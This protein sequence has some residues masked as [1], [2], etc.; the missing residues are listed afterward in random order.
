[1]S[2]HSQPTTLQEW[3]DETDDPTPPT[4]DPE[5]AWTPTAAADGDD[6]N[7]CRG[8][9]EHVSSDFVRVYSA[10][11][12]GLVHACPACCVHAE[13]PAR[14]AG[15]QPRGPKGPTNVEDL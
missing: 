12:E 2:S 4:T 15:K 11:G 6:A 3:T 1:M 9:G 10:R 14:A 8:C 13:L 5:P 7:R